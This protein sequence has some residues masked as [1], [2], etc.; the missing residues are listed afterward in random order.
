MELLAILVLVVM[1][2][3][4][5]KALTQATRRAA[6]RRR[7]RGAPSALADHTVATLR[8]VV[9]ALDEPLVA[10]LSGTP[11]VLHRSTVR[12][13]GKGRSPAGPRPV[14][15]ETTRCEMVRFELATRDGRVIVDGTEADVTIRPRPIIPRKLEREQAFLHTIG[16]DGH[17][18]DAGFD[19]VVIEPGMLVA[20]H[21]VVRVEITPAATGD[22]GFRDAPKQVRLVGDEQHPLTIGPA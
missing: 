2:R 5:A 18:G 12:V 1:T 9:H 16:Y 6:A 20:V 13:F 8:G 7:M 15:G 4:V 3:G 22:V 10:P 19:E 17:A 11:C 14:V 21:G